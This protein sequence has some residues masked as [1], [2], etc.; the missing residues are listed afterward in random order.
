MQEKLEKDCL[1]AWFCNLKFNFSD[2]SVDTFPNKE[3]LG[4]VKET[5]NEVIFDTTGLRP[6]NFAKFK[7]LFKIEQLNPDQNTSEVIYKE[8]QRKG[9]VKEEIIK[10]EKI[11]VSKGYQIKHTFEFQMK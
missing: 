3:N 2:P 9:D 7:I 1:F 5:E 8:N 4:E 10:L 11:K 6:C